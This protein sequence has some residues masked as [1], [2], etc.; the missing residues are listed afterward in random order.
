MVAVLFDETN[1]ARSENGLRPL[2]LSAELSAAAQAHAE[3]ML[4]RG[5]FAHESPEGESTQERVARLAPRAIVLS[6]RENIL[7]T[8]GHEDD[9]PQVRAVDFI[10]GWMDSTGHRRNLLA[11]DIAEV[12]FGVASSLEKGRLTEYAVQVLGRVVGSWTRTPASTLHSPDR[13][14]ARL[15]VPVDFFLEDSA[16][17]AR[18]YKDP[19]DGALSWVGGVRLLVVTDGQGSVVELPRVDPGRYRLLGRLAR[20]DGYQALREIRVLGPFEGS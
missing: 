17:P 5:Y 4:A 10:D 6:V 16:H 7:R 3:D 13:L 18:R 19:A 15:T 2:A 8:E 9:T 20:D 12:G 11:D 14:R 1:R